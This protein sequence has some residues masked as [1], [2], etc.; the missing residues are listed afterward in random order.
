[1]RSV[2]L[3]GVSRYRFWIGSTLLS[4]A[5]VFA[6]VGSFLPWKVQAHDLTP[7]R[8]FQHYGLWAGSVHVITSDYT[9]NLGFTAPVLLVAGAALIA[10]AVA[11]IAVRRRGEAVALTAYMIGWTV[12]IGACLVLLITAYF[13]LDLG[14]DTGYR[15]SDIPTGGWVLVLACLFA[16]VGGLMAGRRPRGGELRSVSF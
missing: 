2:D 13:V 10:C 6:F 15:L 12:W 5:G 11:I 14:A 8:A 16:I 3:S 4:A 7:W 1:M 9:Q